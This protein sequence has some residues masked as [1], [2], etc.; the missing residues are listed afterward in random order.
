MFAVVSPNTKKRIKIKEKRRW[1]KISQ[2]HECLSASQTKKEAFPA[3]EAARVGAADRY[4][5]LRCIPCQRAEDEQKRRSEQPKLKDWKDKSR[6][7]GEPFGY[8][9]LFKDPCCLIYSKPT[10]RHGTWRSPI[11]H[12]I[13]TDET[14]ILEK[15]LLW[16]YHSL[17]MEDRDFSSPL[18]LILES[19][20]KK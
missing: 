6:E 11:S 13:T 1:E 14:A 7:W 15:R 18:S 20:K 16:F 12:L 8:F 10:Y 19:Y 4:N 9:K 3:A 2:W 17:T 5:F